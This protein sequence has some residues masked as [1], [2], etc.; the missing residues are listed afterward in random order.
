MNIEIFGVSA[1]VLWLVLFV[2]LLVIEIA[3]MGLTT[4]WFAGG[5]LAAFLLSLLNVPF[6]WQ[7]VVFLA[8]SILLLFF[9]RPAAIRKFNKSREKT[10]VEGLIGR[11]GIVLS[12]IDNL[13]NAGR[14]QIDGKEWSARNVLEGQ[15]I[16]PGEVVIVQEVS[17]VKLIVKRREEV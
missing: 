9:T 4:I 15:L 10:N 12:E 5:A 14:I 13:Q 11:E 7:F 8:V 16:P 3:T 1:L 6:I 17:G 2:I